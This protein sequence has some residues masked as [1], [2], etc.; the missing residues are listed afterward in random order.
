MILISHTFVTSLLSGDVPDSFV[1]RFRKANLKRERNGI[2]LYQFSLIT[3]LLHQKNPTPHLLP[4]TK[5]PRHPKK[6]TTT[7]KNEER[8][9][10][11]DG[12][13]FW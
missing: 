6:T 11:F 9:D 12:L 1:P 10:S 3:S 7:Q 4:T 5:P 2:L 8:E 13:F